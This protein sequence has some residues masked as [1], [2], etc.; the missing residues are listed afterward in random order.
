MRLFKYLH[1]ART[2]VLD[3]NSIRFTQPLNLN[4]PFEQLPSISTITTPELFDTL[5]HAIKERLSLPLPGFDLNDADLDGALSRLPINGMEKEQFI[6]NARHFVSYISANGLELLSDN[7]KMEKL[8]GVFCELPG[9]A[10]FPQQTKDFLNARVGL[11]CLTKRNDN[12]PMWSHY[13]L[14]SMGYVIEFDPKNSFLSNHTY[15]VRKFSKPH[16]VKYLKKRPDLILFDGKKRFLEKLGSAIFLTKSAQWKYEEEVR[17]IR[18][19]KHASKCIA[20]K[21]PEL[22]YLFKFEPSAIIKVYLGINIKP[23][24]EAEIVAILSQERYSHVQ[25]YRTKLNSKEYTL[26]FVPYEH[27]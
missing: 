22:I 27:K 10:N 19:L 24:C 4:D 1:P 16:K 11:L 15:Q 2:E 8:K 20:D 6:K 25:L 17:L 26:D 7:E 23:E 9:A 13:A 5:V 21:G 3:N 12:I 18:F 14:N